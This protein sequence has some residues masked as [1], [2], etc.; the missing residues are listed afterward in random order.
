MQCFRPCRRG[1]PFYQQSLILFPR[2]Q[3]ERIKTA[4]ISSFIS[5][6][7][8]PAIF[9]CKHDPAVSCTVMGL[10]G[11]PLIQESYPADLRR[12]LHD[13]NCIGKIAVIQLV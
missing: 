2:S 4:Q 10:N 5:S 9:R 13:L 11:L 8:A 1:F 3:I 7:A 12:G 6:R